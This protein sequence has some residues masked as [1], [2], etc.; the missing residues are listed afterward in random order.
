MF[1]R[2]RIEVE[3]KNNQEVFVTEKKIVKVNPPPL[4]E[5]V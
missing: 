1:E 5:V 4:R 3:I 2:D